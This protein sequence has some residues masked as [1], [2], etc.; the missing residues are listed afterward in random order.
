M[1]LE[2]VCLPH[3]DE[4]NRPDGLLMLRLGHARRKRKA[5]FAHFRTL[6]EWVFSVALSMF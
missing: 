1:E 2:V 3:G 6:C 5:S 4:P